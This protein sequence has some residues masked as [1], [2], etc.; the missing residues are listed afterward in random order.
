MAKINPTPDFRAMAEETFKGLP[1]KVAEKARGFFQMSFI[2]E[3]FTDTSF[4][5]WPKRLD[6]HR[7]KLL[8]Q[9]LALRSSI[10]VEQADLKRIAI[11]AGDNLPYAAIHNEGGTITVRVTERMRRYFWAMYHRTGESKY[12][13]MALT[14]KETFTIRIPKRQY[15]GESHT[16]MTRLD[17]M[18]IDRIK[19]AQ[20]NL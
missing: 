10:R 4:I 20:K 17:R 14:R 9:S 6:D 16:L 8:S 12:R 1:A 2:K 3:G 19:E 11:S 15:I 18:F 13:F 5:A 7:H